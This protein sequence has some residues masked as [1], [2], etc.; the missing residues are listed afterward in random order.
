VAS[1]SISS[2]K[3]DSKLRK[4]LSNHRAPHARK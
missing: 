1:K 2:S 4:K 3:N